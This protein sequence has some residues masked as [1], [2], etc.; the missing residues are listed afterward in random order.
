ML[1]PLLIALVAPSFLIKADTRILVTRL[2]QGYLEVWRCSSAHPPLVVLRRPV[3]MPSSAEHLADEFSY[4]FQIVADP[5]T[6]RFAMAEASLEKPGMFHIRTYD[7]GG[8]LVE[9]VNVWPQVLPELYLG[10][11]QGEA[12][13]IGGSPPKLWSRRHPGVPVTSLP[14]EGLVDVESFNTPLH[15][16]ETDQWISLRGIG[17]ERQFLGPTTEVSFRD[18]RFF[19]SRADIARVNAYSGRDLLG[20]YLKPKDELKWSYFRPMRFP[21]LLYRYVRE[22]RSR[23]EFHSWLAPE[24]AED[25]FL[26]ATFVQIDVQS[27][28]RLW[29]FDGI[30]AFVVR[31]EGGAVLQAPARSAKER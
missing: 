12:G 24:M 9:S 31:D 1:V 6:E 17:P 13:L 23:P 5:A 20:F 3:L 16:V 21:N 15:S 22:L 30:S 18:G 4:Q 2:D 26:A 11:L 25:P 28:K 8:R 14:G 27:G 10:F 19:E 29:S 7:S